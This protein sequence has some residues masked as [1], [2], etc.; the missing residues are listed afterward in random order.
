M[1]AYCS[2]APPFQA[3][4]FGLNISKN[5]PFGYTNRFPPVGVKHGG[6]YRNSAGCTDLRTV[7]SY[8]H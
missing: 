6:Y 4:L 2:R 5:R 3:R 7:N 8:Q 1:F